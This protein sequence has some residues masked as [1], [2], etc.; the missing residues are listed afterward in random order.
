MIAVADAVRAEADLTAGLLRCPRC[1]DV[2]RCWGHARWRQVRSI[3]GATVRLRPRRTR[4][5]A[6]LASHVLLPSA[7]LA[8]RADTVEVIGKALL[9]KASGSGYRQIAADLERPAS[10]V[11]RWLRAAGDRHVDKLARRG[12]DH[13]NRLDPDAFARLIPQPTRLGDALNVLAAAAFAARRRFAPH[14]P[15]WTL[16]GVIAGGRLIPTAGFS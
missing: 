8:R 5:Q 9:A 11:R 15:P 10:T 16:I 14:L 4:C 7:V 13:L 12:A 1:G 6:C 3:G 2:L